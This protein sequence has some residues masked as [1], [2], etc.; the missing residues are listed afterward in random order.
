MVENEY[1]AVDWTQ[2]PGTPDTYKYWQQ[3][4]ESPL[5]EDSAYQDIRRNS[6]LGVKD[7]KDWFEESTKPGSNYNDGVLQK[8]IDDL[9]VGVGLLDPPEHVPLDKTLEEV[10]IPASPGYQGPEQGPSQ[11]PDTIQVSY[12]LYD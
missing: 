1:E 6:D 11:V 2:T 3:I 5:F 8:K 7:L 9:A 4:D 12:D 10:L